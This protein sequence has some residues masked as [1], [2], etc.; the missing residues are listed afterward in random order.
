M[1]V[2]NVRMG[3][4]KIG[5]TDSDIMARLSNLEDSFVERKTEGDS[6]D[7]LKTVI[8]FANSAP[9]GYPALMFIGVR[10]DG[11]VPGLANPDST[12]KSLSTKIANSFPV[13]YYLSKVLDSEGRKFIAV[14]VPG[15]EFR[16]HFAG[17]AFVRT[18]SQTVAASEEQFG[19]LIAQR[20]S[21]AYELLKW[22]DKTVS[23]WHPSKA[24]ATYHP[25]TG[26]RNEGKVTECN[27]FYV[28]IAGSP[29]GGQSDTPV[30][31][32]LDTLDIGYDHSRN[33]LEIRFKAPVG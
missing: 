14:I 32:A 27:Q 17:P 8:A 28:T 5:L 3:K 25:T 9:I 6:G 26:Y 4:M 30:S 7:W 20:N 31:F 33:C 11:T 2:E 24:G 16:P 13:P 1:T 23:I 12:Q 22:L 19:R 21:A 29:I 18:G 15:S 10:D